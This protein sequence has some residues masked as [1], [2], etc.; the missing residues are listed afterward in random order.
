MLCSPLAG[1]ATQAVSVTLRSANELW[2]MV[3]DFDL[4]AQSSD[5]EVDRP[6]EDVLSEVP[7]NSRKQFIV[8]HHTSPLNIRRNICEY[9]RLSRLCSWLEDSPGEDTEVRKNALN[10]RSH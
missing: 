7:P 2:M 8:V 5:G 10:G 4:L 3:V 1:D 6:R 9:R